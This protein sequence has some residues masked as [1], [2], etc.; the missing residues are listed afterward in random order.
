MP[1]LLKRHY[2]VRPQ[3]HSGGRQITLAPEALSIVSTGDKVTVLHTEK[4]ALYVPVGTWIDEQAVD[5]A[6]KLL[7]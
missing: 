1:E 7:P 5:Q 6:I 3:G 4:Y 2:K